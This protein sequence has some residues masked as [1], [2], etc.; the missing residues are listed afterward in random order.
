MSRNENPIFGGKNIGMVTRIS[1]KY[2]LIIT[3]AFP[4]MQFPSIDLN[5]NNTLLK[6]K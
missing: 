4:S 5:P 2:I 3:F 6:S 1:P